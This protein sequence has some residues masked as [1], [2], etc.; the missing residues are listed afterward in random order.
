MTKLQRFSAVFLLAAGMAGTAAAQT[1]TNHSLFG[2][3]LVLANP[4]GSFSDAYR[5]GFGLEGIAGIQVAGNV[6][7]QATLGYISYNNEGD[8]PFGNI[9]VTSIKGG[10]RFYPA[11]K[12]FLTANGGLG[13][14]KDETEDRRYS[15]FIGDIGAGVHAG[16]IQAGLFYEGRKKIFSDGFANSV[17]LKLG[18]ALR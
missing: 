6:Y 16:I 2:G 10:V 12:V 11:E 1:K 17:Q 3:N 4:V 13:F 18:I 14:A 7:A 9:N 5:T 8:N 15:R